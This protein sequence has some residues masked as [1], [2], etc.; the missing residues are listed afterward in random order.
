MAAGKNEPAFA[1]VLRLSKSKGAARL[2]LLA[3]ANHAHKDGAGAY[4]KVKTIAREANMS[5][6]WVQAQIQKLV[7]L[8]EL[9]ALNRGRTHETYQFTVTLE[10]SDHE[11]HGEQPRISHGSKGEDPFTHRV[12]TASP[13]GEDRFT[14]RVNTSSPEPS[15][16]PPLEPSKES[17]S[18]TGG[19]LR[20]VPTG[21]R[22]V[23][24]RIA[25]LRGNA[26]R[27][28]RKR[29]RCNLTREDVTQVVASCLETQRTD[30]VLEALEMFSWDDGFTNARGFVQR[31]ALRKWILKE[32][33][34][35]MD[36]VESLLARVDKPTKMALI[37]QAR[38]GRDDL[39]YITSE[40]LHDLH[41]SLE[42]VLA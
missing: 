16:E 12:Q 27:G 17:S 28:A 18:A 34:R 1:R 14:L 35:L 33:P 22:E 31:L 3:I 38:N 37:R 11:D 7:A 26:L 23:I 10:E 2:V 6:R 42:Q 13:Y 29:Y 21:F 39:E 20:E 36:T 30:L 4:P 8:G 19:V 15:I 24:E 41:E 32:L 25:S 5:E 9:T 40:E